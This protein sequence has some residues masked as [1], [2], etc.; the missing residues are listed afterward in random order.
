MPYT[1]IVTG[2]AV[3]PRALRASRSCQQRRYRARWARDRITSALGGE[4]AAGGDRL[5]SRRWWRTSCRQALRCAL[6]LQS[7]QSSGAAPTWSGCNSTLTCRGFA[8][9]APCHWHCSRSG[10]GRQLRMLAPYTTR[11][12]PSPSGVAHAGAASAKPGNAASHRAGEQSLAPR[13]GRLSRASPPEEEHNPRGEPC[14]VEQ[15]GAAG[16]NWVVRTGS[17]CR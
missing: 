5:I 16:A 10:Q 17:G 7:R 9:A 1:L 8:V 12:L 2:P 11:R 13:S 15:T 14:V 4:A 3:E 6:R